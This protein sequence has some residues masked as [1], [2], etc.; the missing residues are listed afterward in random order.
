MCASS[1]CR[2]RLTDKPMR[3]DVVSGKCI[4]VLIQRGVG[5]DNSHPQLRGKLR[6][7]LRG[8]LI[9]KRP[10]TIKFLMIVIMF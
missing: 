7:K 1:L 4:Q 9:I 10:V 3:L 6:H 5:T 2:V 8:I